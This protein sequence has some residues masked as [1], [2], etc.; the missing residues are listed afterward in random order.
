[1]GYTHY[2]KSNT[3]ETQKLPSEEWGEFAYDVNRIF[4]DEETLSLIQKEFD[5]DLPPL[6]SDNNGG[7]ICFNG[8]GD[9]GHETFLFSRETEEFQFCKTAFKPYDLIVTAV[10]SL[11]YSYFG[12]YIKITSDG[13]PGDWNEGVD[14]ASRILGC[15]VLHPFNRNYKHKQKKE[16]N[17]M[18]FRKEIVLTPST[19]ILVTKDTVNERTF[20]QVRIWVKPKGKDDYTPTKKGVAFGLEHTGAIATALLELQDEQAQA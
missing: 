17:T 12:D 14:H 18:H 16:H 7:Y 20:G 8:I 13:G 15:K 11:A 9:G 10:L 3:G 1:M 5:C 19:K 4:N 2:W 6:V